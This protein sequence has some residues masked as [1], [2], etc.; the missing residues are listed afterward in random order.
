MALQK[1]IELENGTQVTYW[2][3]GTIQEDFRGHGLTVTVHGYASQAAREA[4]KTPIASRIFAYVGDEYEQD[5][6]RVQ[7]Y[8]KIK[9]QADFEGATDC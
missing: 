5:I 3:V 8:A 9:Q 7:V 6:T 4:G 2:N 1:S